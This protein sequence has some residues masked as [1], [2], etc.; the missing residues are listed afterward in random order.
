MNHPIR[1]LAAHEFP[2]LIREIPDPPKELYVRGTLPPSTHKLLAVVGS[3][4]YSNYGKQLVEYLVEGLRGHPI[5]IVSGLALGI[6]ALAHE[7]ALRAH[8]HTVAVPGSGLGDP[9]LYPRRNFG[10]AHR[11]LDAGGALLSEYMPDF[12]ATTW[13]FPKRNRIMAGM[14]HA[15]LII[16][17]SERSGTLITAR[18]AAEYN[19]EL[20][21][22][23][24]NIFSENSKGPHQFLKLGATPITTPEDILDV[25]HLEKEREEA[26]I[27]LPVNSDETAVLRALSS[28]TDRDTLIR[29]LTLPVAEANVLLMRMELSG[30]IRED[31]GIFYRT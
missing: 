18:L 28:P 11:I 9:V 4:N 24:G 3:R 1:M 6:D 12:E 13:S 14:C 22:V 17:A 27:P 7:A 23:P 29:T 2:S 30:S 20:L 15:T 25:F 10:L 26:E 21:V 5:T 8:L 19:R 31:N 16:E